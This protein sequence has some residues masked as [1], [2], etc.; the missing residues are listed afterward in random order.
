MHTYIHAGI[1]LARWGRDWGTL[2]WAWTLAVSR[3]CLVR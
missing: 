3:I 1:E 2:V